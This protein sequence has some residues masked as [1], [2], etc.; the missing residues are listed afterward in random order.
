MGHKKSQKYSKQCPPI[1]II[2]GQKEDCESSNS[3]DSNRKHEKDV[4]KNNLKVC[5]NAH[6]KKNVDIDRDLTVKGSTSL[7]GGLKVTGGETVDNLTVNDSLIIPRVNITTSSPIG[8]QA[9]LVY[10]TSDTFVN[11]D[12]LHLSDGK[13]WLT[14]P[15]NPIGGTY[16]IKPDGTGDFPT[17]QAGI[18]YCSSGLK[19]VADPALG[20]NPPPGSENVVLNIMPGIYNESL[21]FNNDFTVAVPGDP[22]EPL[23]NTPNL[24][25]RG[26]ELV[27]DGR[28]IANMTYIMGGTMSNSSFYSSGIGQNNLGAVDS[29]VTLTNVGNTITVTLSASPPPNFV[30]CGVVPGDIIVIT[31]VSGVKQQ[32]NVVSVANTSI[33][34]DGSPAPVS[35][36]GAALTFCS[37]VQVVS[38]TPDAI[39][40]GASGAVQMTGIWFSVNPAFSVT[41]VYGMFF[42]NFIAVTASNLLIDCRN[43]PSASPSLELSS[44]CQFIGS[45][46][47]DNFSGPITVF[48]G[49]YVWNSYMTNG[50]YYVLAN[51]G[52]GAQGVR[53]WD[54]YAPSNAAVDCVQIN[55][56]GTAD[57]GATATGA[58]TE[59]DRFSAFNCSNG[60]ICHNNST[61]TF[62]QTLIIDGCG[63]GINVATGTFLMTGS[64]SYAGLPPT[65]SNCPTA[66]NINAN[67]QFIISRPLVVSG[68][69]TGFLV[70]N[71]SK[72][73][74]TGNVTY[75][76][77]ANPYVV[78]ATSSYSTLHNTGT[79]PSPSNVYTY[80]V[81][82]VSGQ[83]NSGFLNQLIGTPSALTLTMNPADAVGASFLYRGKTYSLYASTQ[84]KHELS[85]PGTF[86][87]GI[88]P[89][90]P[91]ANVTF[92][93]VG[94]GEG[95]TFTVMSNTLVQV[96][97]SN[98]VTF[99]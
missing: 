41:G 20:P 29:T 54:M 39:C 27:G 65:I 77:V 12:Q 63:T 61:T 71:N 72:F 57:G 46:G 87:V 15:A 92:N 35:G 82:P 34:Y 26:L 33:T 60:Y 32:R 40:S 38:A 30:A 81:P 75:S 18:D 43:L 55:G 62:H 7:N 78:D 90:G 84:F 45:V 11:D 64:G 91:K 10:D 25:G 23:P 1:I 42:Q 4:I 51:P 6:F 5:G 98:G 73:T 88:G 58:N 31:D 13:R 14:I 28:P 59:F 17:I 3:C 49:V 85:L 68:A 19:P 50:Y 24:P 99:S 52:Q 22:S 56:A 67:G 48:G 16:I 36:N 9:D 66:L 80:T 8:K 79:D 76:G 89:T 86:F 97:Q 47:S 37:N 95:L 53:C 21:V 70:S 96:L 69:T 83:M 74:S 93:A 2:R 94:P 44:G